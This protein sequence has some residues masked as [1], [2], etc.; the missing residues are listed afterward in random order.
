MFENY[1]TRVIRLANEAK[2]IAFGSGVRPMPSDESLIRAAMCVAMLERRRLRASERAY[3]PMPELDTCLVAGQ[4]TAALDDTD[5]RKAL[6]ATALV[7][8][9]EQLRADV[10]GNRRVLGLPP[11]DESQ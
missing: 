11:Q 5:A 6:V 7:D 4:F 2:H 9:A 8:P 1:E 3:P 10:D